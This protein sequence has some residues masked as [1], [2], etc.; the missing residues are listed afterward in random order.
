MYLP[1]KIRITA[2]KSKKKNKE[3]L[4]ALTFPCFPPPAAKK[5]VVFETNSPNYN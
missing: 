5:A 1:A 4:K 2:L 3:K